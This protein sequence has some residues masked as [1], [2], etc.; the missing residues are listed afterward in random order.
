MEGHGRNMTFG[1]LRQ[2]DC[3]NFQASLG[4]IGRTCL[5]INKIKFK[6]EKEVQ[7]R[8]IHRR[9][10]VVEWVSWMNKL[11]FHNNIK[12]YITEMSKS[13]KSSIIKQYHSNVFSSS[14]YEFLI[15]CIQL[16]YTTM[17]YLPLI[18]RMQTGDYFFLKE[19]FLLYWPYIYRITCW[20][21]GYFTFLFI[22]GFRIFACCMWNILDG[23]LLDGVCM[24]TPQHAVEA[25]CVEVTVSS[26][27]APGINPGCQV[28][29]AGAFT[30]RALSN[31]LFDIFFN[32]K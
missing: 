29:V 14:F 20:Y 3:S 24:H 16:K 13:P 5:K 12:S 22:L 30:C 4:Y 18:T 21:L 31:A 32:L 17:L 23:V 8:D 27:C 25:L 15:V 19:C 7:L 28:D 9:C 1:R 2:K 10:S 11:Q 26:L 6:Q